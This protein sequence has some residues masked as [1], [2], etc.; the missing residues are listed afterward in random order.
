MALKPEDIPSGVAKVYALPVLIQA[1][2]GII[3]VKGMNDGTQVSVY[4]IDG[5]QEGTGVSNHGVANIETSLQAGSVAI[6]SIG[7]KSIKV[8]MR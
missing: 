2:D 8:V 5:K 1:Q 4:D 6:V 7:M 3:T